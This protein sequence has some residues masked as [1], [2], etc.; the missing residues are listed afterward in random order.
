M[1]VS[2]FCWTV[3]IAIRNRQSLISFL[4]SEICLV[5]ILRISMSV[6]MYMYLLMQPFFTMPWGYPVLFF[7]FQLA[8]YVDERK[9]LWCSSIVWLLSAQM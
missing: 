9:D 6:C 8:Y 4:R 7:L 1:L 2:E 3:S 5:L